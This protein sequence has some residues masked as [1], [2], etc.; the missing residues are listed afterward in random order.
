MNKKTYLLI[1]LFAIVFSSVCNAQSDFQKVKDRVVTNLMKSD[2]D[3]SEVTKLLETLK[4]N[5]T[6]P[7]IDYANVSREGFEHRFHSSNMVTLDSSIYGYPSS[8]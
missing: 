3:D 7:G 8:P 4:E 1:A 2:V 5:G 6:W